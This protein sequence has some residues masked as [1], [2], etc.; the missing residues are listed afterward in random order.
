MPMRPCP[1]GC[2]GA[3]VGAASTVS[4]SGMSLP[5]EHP[6]GAPA[7][8]RP[9]CF[10]GPRGAAAVPGREPAGGPLT[11][12]SPAPVGDGWPVAV[13]VRDPALTGLPGTGIVVSRAQGALGLLPF[14][15]RLGG[16]KGR[17]GPPPGSRR[18]VAAPSREGRRIPVRLHR[19]VPGWATRP[20]AGAGQWVAAR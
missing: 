6:R 7:L 17:R 11:P 19:P 9:P 14:A 20:T 8:Y 1:P 16:L 10:R 3:T 13:T 5:I 12:V 15:V 18:W 4:G 2:T